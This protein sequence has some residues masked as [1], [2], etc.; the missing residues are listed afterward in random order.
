MVPL[1]GI[2]ALVG[3]GLTAGVLFCVALSLVPMFL[4]LPPRRYLA[5]HRLIGRHFDPAMPVIVLASA[6]ADVLLAVLATG[7]RWWFALAAALLLSV[8][9]VS[10][11]GN[12]PLNRLVRQDREPPPDWRDPRPRWRALN[13]VRT[14]LAALA[15]LVNAVVFVAQ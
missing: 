10:H 5:A 7:S 14:V 3:S 15:F 4:A 8:S 6:V 12:V 1:L 11:F 13:L 2:V 9:A